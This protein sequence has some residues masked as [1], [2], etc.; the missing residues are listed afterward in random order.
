MSTFE[1]LSKINVNEHV[2]KKGQFKYLSWPFALAEIEKY[3]P[4]SK[5]D[6]LRF[7][8]FPYLKTE[9]GYFVEVAV[10]IKGKTKSQLHPVLDSYNKTVQTP[11]A[12][13]INTSIQRCTVKAISLH[14]LGLYIYAGEDLPMIEDEVKT[15]KRPGKRIETPVLDERMEKIVQYSIELIES[16]DLAFC[17]EWRSLVRGDQ[18]LLWKCLTSSQKKSASAILET[19]RKNNLKEI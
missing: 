11:N 13:Q 17:N 15:E 19:E 7:D 8:G 14:G 10:T 6:V 5:I 2:E 12:F 4:E 3:D 18:E 1:D 16:D 9:L